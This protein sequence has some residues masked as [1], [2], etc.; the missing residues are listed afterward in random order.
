MNE[1][2]AFFTGLSI[3]ALTFDL[4]DRHFKKKREKIEVKTLKAHFVAG[5]NAGTRNHAIWIR[6]V[7]G[8]D[9]NGFAMA[10]DKCGQIFATLTGSSEEYCTCPS[11]KH[12]NPAPLGLETNKEPW[13]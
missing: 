2:I 7:I 10:C 6:N 3:G 8:N 5:L 13:T 11:C 1:I 12:R 9:V 4:I